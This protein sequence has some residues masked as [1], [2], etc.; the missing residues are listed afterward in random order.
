MKVLWSRGLA[1]INPAVQQLI[2]QSFVSRAWAPATAQALSD[3][4]VTQQ[5]LV[6]GSLPHMLSPGMVL[7]CGHSHKMAFRCCC[8]AG[9]QDRSQAAAACQMQSSSKVTVLLFRCTLSGHCLFIFGVD[10]GM[11]AAS[12][13]GAQDKPASSH[14]RHD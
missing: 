10:L 2:V 4:L 11:C 12:R 5:L 1:H 13:K 8:I 3:Q 9:W 6:C 14:Q 7:V